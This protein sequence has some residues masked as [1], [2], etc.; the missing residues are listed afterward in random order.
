M[1]WWIGGFVIAIVVVV[2]GFALTGGGQDR[3]SRSERF[4][5]WPRD[6]ASAAPGFERTLDHPCGE[7]AVAKVSKLPT[8][9]DGP[10]EA[11]LVVELDSGGKVIH[12]WPMPVDHLP[13]AVRGDELL[14]SAGDKGVWVRA[15]GSFRR[16]LGAPASTV[17]LFACDLTSVFGK[18]DYA[19][20]GVFVDVESHKERTLGYQGVCT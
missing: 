3:P 14:V 5:F 7:V 9:K 11:E 2:A 1:R 10:L 6:G 17:K 19:Q 15:D 12:R 8:A 16:E 20:C 4:A 18:S 13:R